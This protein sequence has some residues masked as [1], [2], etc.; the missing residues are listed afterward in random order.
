MKIISRRIYKFFIL[1]LIP[2][3][4]IVGCV[5]KDILDIDINN[6]NDIE[7]P[8]LLESDLEIS[9]ITY[10][11]IPSVIDELFSNLGKTNKQIIANKIKHNNVIIDLKEIKKTI[12]KNT[13]GES[14]YSFA[15]FVESASIN[16]IYNLI[17]E[18]DK[19]GKF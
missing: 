11:E 7:E 15:L 4:F 6:I 13:P 9:T 2:S 8:V 14:S 18:K 10:N 16:P 1:Y 17:I 3:M 19:K 5:E 12:N